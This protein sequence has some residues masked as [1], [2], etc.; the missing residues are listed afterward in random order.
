MGNPRP[1]TITSERARSDR[2]TSRGL[3][4]CRR[5]AANQ[6]LT[7]PGFLR[8]ASGKSSSTEQ[9]KGGRS[10][11]CGVF[12][13]ERSSVIRPPCLTRGWLPHLHYR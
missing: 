10:Q 1:E 12:S 8:H 3:F 5:Q 4:G 9:F 6:G 11:G 7:D 13:R 2:V